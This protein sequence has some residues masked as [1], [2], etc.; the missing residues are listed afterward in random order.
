MI[1]WPI[2]SLIFDLSNY[3]LIGSSV[4]YVDCLCVMLQQLRKSPIKSYLLYFNYKF[5]YNDNAYLYVYAYFH[6]NHEYI[7]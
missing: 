4:C 5:H 7:Y 2:I 3:I 6:A 1:L